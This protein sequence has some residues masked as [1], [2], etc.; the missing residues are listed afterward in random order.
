MRQ[1]TV[2]SLDICPICEI[3]KTELKRLEIPFENKDM[4]DSDSIAEL[5]ISGVYTRNAPVIQIENDDGTNYFY[6]DMLL[7]KSKDKE[8]V[9][10][11]KLYQ[12]LFKYGK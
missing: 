2:Y 4:S 10:T 11:Y 3:V 12:E 6:D 8:V 5:A 7:N 9:L 1:I